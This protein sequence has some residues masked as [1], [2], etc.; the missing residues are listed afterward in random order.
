MAGIQST[1]TWG[2]R[3]M[4]ILILLGVVAVWVILQAWALP[5]MGVKT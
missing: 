4:E 1:Q 3:I 2:G 5:R